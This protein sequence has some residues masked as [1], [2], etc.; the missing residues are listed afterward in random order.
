[1]LSGGRITVVIDNPSPELAQRL[2]DDRLGLGELTIGGLVFPVRYT[3]WQLE[4][5]TWDPDNKTLSIQIHGY[6]EKP[7][8]LERPEA[9]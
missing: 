6:L 4:G 8:G 2:Y 5:S 3:N 1:M 9:R 7:H